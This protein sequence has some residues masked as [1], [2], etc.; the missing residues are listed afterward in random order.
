MQ[1]EETATLYYYCLKAEILKTVKVGVKEAV[2]ET[3][4]HTMRY[5]T[6]R[7]C[8]VV[9]FWIETEKEIEIL[10]EHVVDWI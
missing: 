2:L 1:G 6:L 7:G 3:L 8:R 9:S 4:G 10:F 5:G